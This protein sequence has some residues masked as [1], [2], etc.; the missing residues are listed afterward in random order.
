MDDNS[1]AVDRIAQA[2][3]DGV[4]NVQPVAPG[5]EPRPDKES[6]RNWSQ[7]EVDQFVA[8]EVKKATEQFRNYK[9]MAKELESLKQAEVERQRSE[10]SEVEKRDAEISELRSQIETH[11][12]KAQEYARKDT[13][14]RVLAEPK[15]ASL[16]WAYRD[17]VQLDDDVETVRASADEV[18]QRFNQDFN[19]QNPTIGVPPVGRSK[20]P[21]AAHT[22]KSLLHAAIEKARERLY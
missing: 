9:D 13:R 18:L 5:V 22:N 2:V 19:N 8:R 4:Q 16:T 20:D 6:T 10:M 12:A 3:E 14:N 11:A 17:A 1:Q 15:Y 7:S 21:L